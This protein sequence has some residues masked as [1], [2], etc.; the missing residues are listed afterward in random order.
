MVQAGVSGGGRVRTWPSLRS[1][2]PVW[3]LV[4][5][6]RGR[7]DAHEEQD[8]LLQE[9]FLADDGGPGADRSGHVAGPLQRGLRG[10]PGTRC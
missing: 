1:C 5:L 7:Q 3:L 2:L 8:T 9:A 10:V 4:L 6:W